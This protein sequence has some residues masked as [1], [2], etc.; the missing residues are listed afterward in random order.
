MKQVVL[1]LN[2]SDTEKTFFWE[3][4][5]GQDANNIKFNVSPK[6]GTVSPN[7]FKTIDITIVP[8]QKV[9]LLYF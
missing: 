7:S 3:A 9:M 5:F 8:S 6:R 4:P 2:K 1:L